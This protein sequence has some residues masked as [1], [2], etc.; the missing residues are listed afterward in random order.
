MISRPVP[1][2]AT[3][4]ANEAVA[5]VAYRLSELFAIYPITP[6]SP[7][8]EWV[9]E[10]SSQGRKNLWNHVPEVIQ[11]QSEGGA[12]GTLH[13]AL[14]AGAL[15]SSFTASQGLLLMI[16]NLYKIAGEL[17]PFVLHVT[18]RSLATHALSIFCDHGDVMA[19]RQTGSAMLCANSVQEALDFSAIAHAATLRTRVP[20]IHFFDGFRTSHEVS[21]IE[22]LSDDDLRAMIDAGAVSE[23]LSR[24][25]TPT[26]RPSAAPRRTPTCSSR[27]ARA[28]TSST[29]PSPASCRNCSTALPSAPGAPTSCMTTRARRM[30]TASSS[31]WARAP[32]PSPKPPLG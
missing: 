32:R 31:S 1:Q 29:M 5:T 24:A 16:P 22:V 25:L 12:A 30:P 9:D 21:K 7:M 4:D 27:R 20:F 17:H 23:H 13:G 6:S 19:C 18:A 10:W 11:L 14:N 15:A 3:L 2:T 26:T 8:G 28:P